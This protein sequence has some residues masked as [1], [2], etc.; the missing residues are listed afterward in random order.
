MK[1]LENIENMQNIDP[2][3]LFPD[4]K[5]RNYFLYFLFCLKLGIICLAIGAGFLIGSYANYV[6]GTPGFGMPYFASISIL[7]GIG[8]IIFYWQSD[9]LLKRKEKELDN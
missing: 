6:M 1:I 2:N 4:N 5:K 3:L 8:L 7:I 9:K